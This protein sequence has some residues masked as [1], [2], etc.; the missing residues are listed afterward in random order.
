MCTRYAAEVH[1]APEVVHHWR[2][3]GLEEPVDCDM[4]YGRW[5]FGRGRRYAFQLEVGL[6]CRIGSLDFGRAGDVTGVL[7][8]QFEPRR[9]CARRCYGRYL[10]DW[11]Y[12]M[13]T[14]FQNDPPGR[15]RA[16]TDGIQRKT[17]ITRGDIDATF[18]RAIDDVRP[19]R[20]FIGS[21]KRSMGGYLWLQSFLQ[22]RH[23]H[24]VK[25]ISSPPA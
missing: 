1:K 25:E 16:S 20:S 12:M 2:L 17:G 21:D 19:G 15:G 14:R 18:D 5:V 7:R 3:A 6:G 13:V 4:P 8:R 22:R 9:I 11:A 23:Q 24:I 10:I